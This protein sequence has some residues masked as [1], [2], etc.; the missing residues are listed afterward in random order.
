M[1]VTLRDFQRAAI[2]GGT[3]RGPGVIECLRKHRSTIIVSPTGTGKTEMFAYVASIAKEQVL[4]LADR[5][6]LVQQT[7]KRLE[8]ATGRRYAIEQGEFTAPRGGMY[9]SGVV[10]CRPS[11]HSRL[12]KHRRDRFG[13]IIV[14]EAD[15]SATTQYRDIFDYFGCAKI[16]MVTGTP[17]RKDK[18]HIGFE[19]VAFEYTLPDAVDDGWLV[20]PNVLVRQWSMVDLSN[21]KMTDGSLNKEQCA[22]QVSQKKAIYELV[23]ETIK[24]GDRPAIVFAI[25]VEQAEEIAN[26]LNDAKPGS[27]FAGSYRTEKA[28][29]ARLIDGWKQGDYQY[30]VNVD[31]AA[32]G[33]D[34]PPCSL[35]VN[36]AP[37]GSR[38]K[39]MQRIGRVTR[40]LRGTVDGPPTPADRRA[41]IAASAKPDAIVLDFTDASDRHDLV[42]PAECLTPG[43]LTEREK[44]CLSQVNREGRLQTAKEAVAKARQMAKEQEEEIAKHSSRAKLVVGTEAVFRA[45][46]RGSVSG[47]APVSDADGRPI[48]PNVMD[49]LRR[50][51]YPVDTSDYDAIRGYQRDFIARIKG[52]RPSLKME[53]LILRLGAAVP[54]TRRA[55]SDLIDRLLE[56][57]RS[58]RG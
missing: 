35:V 52:G 28:K 44:R 41:A 53:R 1:P 42:H 19:S 33:L 58:N 25:D 45:P 10:A 14:D 48:T 21:I 32:R 2:H 3:E 36:G 20:E 11:I 9:Y 22:K 46:N 15:L 37:T 51:G 49:T 29:R 50:Q 31:I 39:M 56:A 27:A 54:K 4:V 34:H 16:L 8:E 7:H 43:S 57:K 6:D 30:F 26:C 40:P 47:S 12:A 24:F 18:K 5:I 38:A 13:L 17:D 23:G 55:A